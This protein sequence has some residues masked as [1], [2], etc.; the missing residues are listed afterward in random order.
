VKPLTR[1]VSFQVPGWVLAAALL[2]WLWPATGLE[3]WIGVVVFLLWVVKDFAM[4][5]LLRQ[6]YRRD[7]ATGVARLIGAEAVVTSALSPTGYVTVNGERWRAE[8][9]PDRVLIPVGTR[10]LVEGVDGL[11]LR[12][13]PLA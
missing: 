3:A 6:A 1:Y 13:Q 10:V 7:T 8:A 9:P 12:V 4:Y 2:L 11:T 5:P